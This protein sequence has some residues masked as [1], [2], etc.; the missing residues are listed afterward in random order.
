MEFSPYHSRSTHV[1]SRPRIDASRGDFGRVSASKL[2]QGRSREAE[3][4]SSNH[5]H[6]WARTR[7]R[8]S[9]VDE[10]ASI[11]VLCSDKTGTLTEN[12][13][14]VT[15]F[16]AMP[17]FNESHVLGV[18]ALPSSDGGD[19]PV[20]GAI[21]AA[22]A[23]KVA[24]D[25]PTLV[26]FIPFDPATKMSEATATDPGGAPVRAVKGAFA[27]VA[28]LT[29]TDPKASK[30]ANE[31]EAKGFRVMAV[32]VGPT[33]ALKL[34]GIIALSDPP[35]PDSAALI[36]ELHT[37]G[38]RGVMVTG[39]AAA[40]AAIVAHDVG[41]DGKRTSRQFTD[42]RHPDQQSLATSRSL[43]RSGR[44]ARSVR[45][46][47]QN[48]SGCKAN[49]E[50]SPECTKNLRRASTCARAG[51]RRTT[52]PLGPRERTPRFRDSHA[53]A[54]WL[55]RAAGWSRCGGKAPAT[56]LFQPQR[57]QSNRDL[58][59]HDSSTHTLHLDFRGITGIGIT[60]WQG[61]RPGR[62]IV[63]GWRVTRPERDPILPR[64]RLMTRR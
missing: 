49:A 6:R 51:L 9:A 39:D 36:A 41:L 12:A 15:A 50:C 57:Q 62:T 1:C 43:A 4:R 14:T 46:R 22:A 34:V 29:Q 26:K 44:Y 13:L 23:K 60:R 28:R 7:C 38:V 58:A 37:L 45:G 31:L 2:F 24:S 19:D 63:S 21:R 33:T 32:A 42:W 3:W 18:A 55:A 59:C 27:A 11:D 16:H 56:R 48:R 47:V 52:C 54:V 40:T 17:G 5:A 8:R 10:A 30:T 25:L 61:R 53:S 35:R 64:L 20:N